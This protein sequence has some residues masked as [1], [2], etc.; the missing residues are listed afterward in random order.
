MCLC[1][2]IFETY[3]KFQKNLVKELS[4]QVKKISNENKSL[5]MTNEKLCRNLRDL[6]NKKE[7]VE[8]EL[9][10]CNCRIEELQSVARLQRKG[11]KTLQLECR[12]AIEAAKRSENTAVRT[13]ANT[14][15]GYSSGTGPVW[16][17]E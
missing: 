13:C 3:F 12:L 6:T 16:D 14:M 15:E 2:N 11:N 17:V 4:A 10:K 1:E 5:N 7:T 8:S 9:I